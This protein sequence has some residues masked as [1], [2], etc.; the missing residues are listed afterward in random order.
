MKWK[1]E[2]A[3]CYTMQVVVYICHY[4]KPNTMKSL[5][6]LL[7]ILLFVGCT[8]TS[9]VYDSEFT[10]T[11]RDIIYNNLFRDTKA[12]PNAKLTKE[13][14]DSSSYRLEFGQDANCSGYILVEPFR[15]HELK[16]VVNYGC[17]DLKHNTKTR[18]DFLDELGG[19]LH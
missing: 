9:R 2:V 6:L 14:L 8:S 18:V 4:P 19:L 13:T 11:N 5:V 17:V 10:K 7:S 15:K 1:I 16:V 3:I 12:L